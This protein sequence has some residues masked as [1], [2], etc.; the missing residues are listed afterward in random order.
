MEYFKTART[1]PE[2]ARRIREAVF[3]QEQGFVE[4]FDEKD[5]IA[6]HIVLYSAQDQP[7]ATC[8]YF[9]D[10]AG[11]VIGRIAVMQAFRR[12][13]YG[14]RV[15]GEA[16]RQIRKTGA[17]VIRLAAQVR[18]KGFYEKSGYEAVGDP[19]LDEGCPHIWMEKRLDV[20]RSPARAGEA[21]RLPH[22]A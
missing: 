12:H 8:R 5:A 13:A 6:V 19:F 7:V 11:Y 1:M 18:A 20:S 14:A 4:E 3:V 10:P 15:L 2:A 17:P 22:K 16:E 21:G 9:P